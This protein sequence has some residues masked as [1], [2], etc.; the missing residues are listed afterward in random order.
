MNCK[1]IVSS[2][3]SYPNIALALKELQSNIPVILID[4]DDIPEGTIRFAEFAEDLSVNTDCLKSVNRSGK[5]VAIL[6]FS[7]GT[8]GFP[9]A[10]VLTHESIVTLNEMILVPEVVGVREASGKFFG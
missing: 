7:S 2:K 4:N 9:K 5:D 6:P 8:T 1:A 3:L 10:V